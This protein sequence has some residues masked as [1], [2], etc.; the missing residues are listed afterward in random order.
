MDEHIEELEAEEK[1]RSDARKER[2]ERA[3]R[4]A[5]LH[6]EGVGRNKFVEPGLFISKKQKQKEKKSCFSDVFFFFFRFVNLPVD[7]NIQDLELP[8]PKR[9]EASRGS[10]RLVKASRKAAKT[11]LSSFQRRGMVETEGKRTSRRYS[12]IEYNVK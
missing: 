8:T 1:A 4:G 5:S 10:L 6:A 7:K 3:E 9:L 11:V 2:R 12:R